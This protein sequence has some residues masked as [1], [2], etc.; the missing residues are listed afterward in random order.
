MWIYNINL[1]N[2]S[3]ISFQSKFRFIN[4]LQGY[5]FF[6]IVERNIHTFNL[7]QYTDTCNRKVHEIFV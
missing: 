7:S 4:R 2:T 1:N 3:N 5:I 6:L